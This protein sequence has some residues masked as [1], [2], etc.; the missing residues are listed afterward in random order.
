VDKIAAYLPKERQTIFTTATIDD[1]LL[2]IETAKS[3]IT[4]NQDQ[5]SVIRTNQYSKI[6]ETLSQKYIY[7]PTTAKMYF[8]INF[9]T[10]FDGISI[11]IFCNTCKD[12]HTL[13]YILNH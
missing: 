1:T 8:F 12:V 4:H 7:M 9:L 5:I 11:I 6:A 2:S 10:K 3:L 13:S